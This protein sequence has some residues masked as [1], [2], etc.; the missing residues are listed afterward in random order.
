MSGSRTRGDRAR[1]GATSAALLA[2]G[3]LLT[4]TLL[5]GT[6][7]TGTL[8]AADIA[9]AADDVQYNRDI[10]RVLS[11]KCFACHGRDAEQREGDLR[12]DERQ[13]VLVEAESGELPIVPGDAS[14]SEVYRRIV[15][16]DD[17]ARM[18]PPDESKQLTKEE[19]DLIRRWI[20][21]G[22]KY[23]S[24]WS[25]EPI[26]KTRPPQTQSRHVVNNIDRYVLARLEREGLQPSPPADRRVLIRRLTLGLTGLPPTPGEVDAF[27]R[28]KDPIDVA[29]E[30]V[31]DRLLESPRYGE[32]MAFAWLEAARYAD[33]DGYESDPLR[34]MWP[35]RDWVVWAMNENMPYDQFIVEQLAGD[36]LPDATMRQRLATGFNRN[37]RLN[38][39]GG[40]LPEEWLVEYVADRAETTATVFMGLTWACGRCH[41]HK[42]DPQTQADY[43]RLFAFFNNVP[44]KGSARGGS[45]AQPMMSVPRLLDIESFE[46]D[47]SV[48]GKLRGKQ[49]E[50]GATDEFKEAFQQW[51]AQLDAEQQAKLPKELAKPPVAKWN[52]KH[53]SQ[54]RRHFLENVHAASS[55]LRGQI[56]PLQRK[57][58]KMLKT[59][60]KVMVMAD[61]AEPRQTHV[62]TRGA[63]NL[64]A[65]PVSAATPAWL[66]PM[67][68]SWPNNRLGLARWLVD[69]RHPLTARVT[70]NR[71]WAHHFGVGLVKTQD[72]FGTQGELPSHPELLDYLA[73]SFMESGWNGK[74]LHKRIVMSNTF[75][76]T[77]GAPALGPVT[78]Q[79]SSQA[80]RVDYELDPENRLLA[81]GPRFR[82]TAAV[83]R[84]QALAVSG[85][86][87]E[88]RGG[89]P[90]KPY[91]V[92][93]LWREIIKGGPTYKPDTGDKLYRRSLYTLWRRAVKP[94]L[95]TL[96]DANQRDTCKVTQQRTNTPLQALLLLNDVTFVEAARNLAQRMIREGGDGVADRVTYGVTLTTSRPPTDQELR[97]LQEE[98][99]SYLKFYEATPEAAK[100]LVAVG[101][102]SPDAKLTVT[103][104]AAYTALARLLLNLDETI[105]KE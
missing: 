92:D 102:S 97:I 47:F 68:E 15:S 101:E 37:H 87:V 10:R 90:V 57:Q 84:D 27:V 64:P 44:E 16:D 76:Q 72:D 94:P 56:A 7:L 5:T 50:V 103:D 39:E 59:G 40:I 12:L 35:W 41:E 60:A 26:S 74:A 43:Y 32:H 80:K 14:A 55:E 51:V 79:P 83:I 52:D 81:R 62:L 89:P 46:A 6:L 20:A 21:Q 61:M 91:Q 49:N 69:D 9:N 99:E 48:L 29:Y 31:V 71:F 4:G 100:S 30:R 93:G 28:D 45:N 2:A 75:R 104:L 17:D 34:N 8:V 58:T 77:S 73:I 1:R 25:F 11:D 42:Y 3:T 24:H 38:N 54:A 65:E 85:L 70:V 22:A 105:T 98:V 13:D 67:D 18:P 78:K 33:S 19:I 36:L 53:R 82:L 96:L 66:P 23:Q 63:Y 95:M 88:R 86:L